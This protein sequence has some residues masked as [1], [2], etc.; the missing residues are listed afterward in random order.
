MFAKLNHPNISGQ[1]HVKFA[2]GDEHETPFPCNPK[3]GK[4]KFLWVLFVLNGRYNLLNE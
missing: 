1:A 3:E 4:G 2:D